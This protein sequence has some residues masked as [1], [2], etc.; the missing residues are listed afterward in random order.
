MRAK[1]YLTLTV[2]EIWKE[3]GSSRTQSSEWSAGCKSTRLSTDIVLC[4]L[5]C[6]L[7]AVLIIY[8]TDQSKVIWHQS[9]QYY[10]FDLAS[11]LN[12]AN[13]TLTLISLYSHSYMTSTN[14]YGVL[15]ATKKARS[16]NSKS[17]VND[18]LHRRYSDWPQFYNFIFFF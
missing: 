9:R 14:L 4:F 3:D 6:A 17:Q 16:Y 13:L 8:L 5:C 10:K 11:H 7:C 1:F 15:Q 18:G 12:H 2:E